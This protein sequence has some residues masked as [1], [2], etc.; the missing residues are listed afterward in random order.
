MSLFSRM[1]GGG[2]GSS[3]ARQPPPQQRSAGVQDALGKLQSTIELLQKKSDHLDKKIHDELVM[4]KKYGKTDRTK[5]LAHLK[6]KKRYE[7]QQMQLQGQCDT[8][9]AQMSALEATAHT[10]VVVEAM[11]TG[12]SALKNSA[13]NV[14]QVDDLMADVSEQMQDAQEVTDLLSNPVGFGEQYD[15]DDL[16]AEL[17]ELEE[18]ELTDKLADVSPGEAAALDLPSVPAGDLKNPAEED[19]EELDELLSWAA[20]PS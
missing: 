13:M 12:S 7:K 5:A 20:V 1:F 10:Q 8:L 19:K 2:G 6:R 14:D 4:V 15:M 9:E 18:D 17:D 11:K 3:A 16:E